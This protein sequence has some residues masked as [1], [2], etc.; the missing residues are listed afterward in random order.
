MHKNLI[1]INE[2]LAFANNNDGAISLIS[3]KT[4]DY[5]FEDI[6]D[7]EKEIDELSNKVNVEANEKNKITSD[8]NFLKDFF[9]IDVF[10]DILVSAGI[11]YCGIS[12]FGISG[13]TLLEAAL[14]V[15]CYGGLVAFEVFH[16]KH[17]IKNYKT[18]KKNNKDVKD[19]D[20][21]IEKVKDLIN[22]KKEE[23]EHILDK[24]DFREYTDKKQIESIMSNMF[25]ITHNEV[26]NTLNKDEN[27][28][29]ILDGPKLN[30]KRDL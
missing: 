17:T 13:I 4:N 24:V 30:R 22:S 19:I 6:I 5:S 28:K 11:I 25:G 29:V 21:G 2:M 1:K 16:I 18:I 12:P 3:K 10:M 7:K 26:D 27:N 20:E 14:Y 8:N 15:P 9:P 23:L